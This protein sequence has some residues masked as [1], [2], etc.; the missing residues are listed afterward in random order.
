M[1]TL[2][3]LRASPALPLAD[4]VGHHRASDLEDDVRQ[5]EQIL[6]VKVREHRQRLAQDDR[7]KEH[8]GEDHAQEQPHRG[9]PAAG[10]DRERQPEQQKRDRR[11]RKCDPLVQLDFELSR[12]L[13]ELLGQPDASHEIGQLHIFRPDADTHFVG[14]PAIVE[15]ERKLLGEEP[16][17]SVR[18]EIGA[19]TGTLVDEQTVEQLD[20]QDLFFLIHQKLAALGGD[21]LRHFPAIGGQRV[22][23]DSFQ[24]VVP[25][26]VIDVDDGIFDGDLP[27]RL[28]KGEGL[29]DRGGFHEVARF[30]QKRRPDFNLK[31]E[32]KQRQQEREN[33]NRGDDLQN[34]NS[35]GAHCR[36]LGIGRHPSEYQHHGD[37]DRPRHRERQY[38]RQNVAGEL[39]KGP[40]RDPLR[41]QIE[42]LDQVR[43]GHPESQNRDRHAEGEQKSAGDIPV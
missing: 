9:F 40:E 19:G 15:T 2:P 28:K 10:P 3:P 41:H 1:F 13:I 42:H 14:L 43:A 5:P 26:L 31:I 18:S 22:D 11:K 4:P 25:L 37:H 20:G 39:E 21:I 36:N 12:I 17:R 33:Q 7:Q 23:L 29:I 6:R 38:D 24:A 8:P 32:A 30:P 27:P 35:A 16:L 34:R